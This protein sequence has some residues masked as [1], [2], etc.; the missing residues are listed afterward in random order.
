VNGQRWDLKKGP[1]PGVWVPWSR[2]VHVRGSR[3]GRRRP[4][5]EEPEASL[6]RKGSDFEGPSEAAAPCGKRRGPP[7]RPS[8][9]GAVGPGKRAMAKGEGLYGKMMADLFD[10][11]CCRGQEGGFEGS[12]FPIVNGVEN[13]HWGRAVMALPRKTQG[14]PTPHPARGRPGSGWCPRGRIEKDGDRAWKTVGIG[15]PCVPGDRAL[16]FTSRQKNVG[17]GGGSGMGGPS[18]RPG[19]V[20]GNYKKHGGHPGGPALRT[21]RRGRASGISTTQGRPSDGRVA[22][23]E[24][25]GNGRAKFVKIIHGRVSP[26]PGVPNARAR[27]T[28]SVPKKVGNQRRIKMFKKPPSAV[29]RRLF[30]RWWAPMGRSAQEKALSGGDMVGFPAQNQVGKKT[31]RGI[32][33]PSHHQRFMARPRTKGAGKR[34]AARGVCGG[35]GARGWAPGRAQDP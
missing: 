18:G 27:Q 8:L 29:C 3:G 28:A 23:K 31:P 9:S 17:L 33:P 30:S 10:G 35:F 13:P 2:S 6:E 12:V 19:K 14:T 11:F 5:K 32:V 26:R 1:P 15:G 25:A 7:G 20:G 21:G 16:L 34:T 22:W 24:A 4:P